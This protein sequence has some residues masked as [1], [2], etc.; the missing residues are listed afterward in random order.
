MTETRRLVCLLL[1]LATVVWV[2][3]LATG[4]WLASV[5]ASAGGWLYGVGALICHQRPDRSFHL[6][7][8]QL[9]V[10]ARCFGLYAGGAVGLVIWSLVNRRR[11]T[12]WPPRPAVLTVIAAA[13]PTALTVV[14]AWLGLADPSNAWRAIL[15]APLGVAS[16]LVIGAVTTDHLK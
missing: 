1:A 15:A 10:C 12:P 9:P 13:V 2:A 8:A 3:L 5:A 7:A 6:G 11:Q 14:T 4:P 16:G